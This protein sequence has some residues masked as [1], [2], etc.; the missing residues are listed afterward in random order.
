M[1]F[2]FLFVD[3]RGAEVYV[4]SP[5]D[6]ARYVRSGALRGEALLYDSLTRE[7][8]PARTHPAFARF[9]G[10]ERPEGPESTGD[11]PEP[12]P[13][14]STAAAGAPED[15]EGSE[16]PGHVE[17]PLPDL[18]PLPEDAV[19]VDT[20]QL[21]MQ[22]QELERWEDQRDHVGLEDDSLRLDGY[23][24]MEAQRH[25]PISGSWGD[26]PPEPGDPGFESFL[27]AQR[28][29]GRSQPA[30]WADS[31]AHEETRTR[32]SGE[33][34]SA[35]PDPGPAGA[36]PSEVAGV[37]TASI[38]KSG[39]LTRWYRRTRAR[40]HHRSRSAG[41]RQLILLVPLLAIG[42]LGIAEAWGLSPL[43]SA[44][45][46]WEVADSTPDVPTPLTPEMEATEAEA[47]QDMVLG[48]ENLRRTMRVG[49]PPASWMGG[50]YLSNALGFP[51]VRDYW[52]RYLD[53][54]D[55]L[56]QSEQDL[57]RSGFVTRLRLQGITGPALSIRLAQALEHFEE[58]APRR[59]V[60][61]AGMEELAIAA[62]GL[63]D[64]LLA[65]V[66]R[67]R[68]APVDQG[69]NDDPVLEAVP[70][71]ADTEEALWTRIER[72]VQAL[73]GVADADP[74]ERRDVSRSVLGSLAL[75]EPS[76]GRQRAPGRV[77]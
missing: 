32:G 59:E 66:E 58:D 1:R 34:R 9:R 47:F 44:F 49:K 2:R 27:N 54:V 13:D 28:Q 60:T 65:N 36:A 30:R 45:A 68:Y 64:F 35:F 40:S 12:S 37:P 16:P 14:Q 31:G 20:L 50:P 72:L 46:D 29:W 53:Y 23:H 63:H 62:L 73:D 22:Q 26:T 43:Q 39:A 69:V 42:G 70:L 48:M 3:D 4:S 41:G 33:G 17:E 51:D 11:E 10:Q 71:D 77:P 5:E 25:A 76:G 21:F 15:E 55:A 75:P 19:Q 56:R 24:A 61:Y 18:D 8:A 38:R 52:V 6:L 7:W 74:L 57:F 67:I